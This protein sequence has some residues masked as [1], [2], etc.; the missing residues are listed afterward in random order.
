MALLSKLEIRFQNAG[1]NDDVKF[2]IITNNRTNA[3]RIRNYSRQLDVVIV[4]NSSQFAQ[5]EDRSIYIFNDCGQIV[6]VIHYPYS[7]VQKPL[8]KAA[9]LSGIY[10]EPCGA[11]NSMASIMDP[12]G[13]ATESLSAT[14]S[15]SL[16][17]STTTI[18]NDQSKDDG[19]TTIT[20]MAIDF[21]P[22]ENEIF[23]RPTVQ[24]SATD[25]DK[26]NDD[27]SDYSSYLIPLKIILPVEHVHKTSDNHSFTRYNYILLK[28]D[29]PSFHEHINTDNSDLLISVNANNVLTLTSDNTDI[30]DTTTDTTNDKSSKTVIN[31]TRTDG[32][33]KIKTAS[34]ES[35][36]NLETI[37][38]DTQGYRYELTKHHEIMNENGEAAVVFD[39]IGMVRPQ[40]DIKKHISRRIENDD[41]QILENNDFAP[42]ATRLYERHYMKIFGWL[43]Y[44]L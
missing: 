18:T 15:N 33:E 1:F 21:S 6:F 24:A 30:I 37:L 11:C 7:S 13:L 19:S 35:E 27:L 39:D 5:L 26:D 8:V 14:S 44:Q 9:I 41:D 4:N 42:N 23:K 29:D 3:K 36:T 2:V 12:I 43:H 31:E 40:D 34:A 16:K 28:S 25:K 10:D 17:S 38:V 32:D 20:S 22:V